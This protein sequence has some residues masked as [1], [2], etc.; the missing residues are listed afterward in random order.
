MAPLEQWNTPSQPAGAEAAKSDK[1]GVDRP[2]DGRMLT[3][4]QFHRLA[5]V[6]PE[7]EWFANIENHHTRRNYQNDVRDFVQFIGMEGQEEFRVVARAHLIAWRQDL[8]NR[9]LAPATIRRKLSALTSLFDYLC[10]QNAITHNPVKGV[11]RPKEGTNEGKTPAL[12]DDQAR[13]LLRQPATDTLQGKRD[14][15]IL[16]ALLY[17]GLRREEL[18]KLKVRDFHTREGLMHLKLERKGGKIRYEAVN[19]TTVTFITEYLRA[20]GHEEELNAPLFRPVKMKTSQQA[21]T[22][23]HTNTIMHLVK[24]YAKEAGVFFPG[25]SPHAM[26]AT[27]AT[28]ALNHGADIAKVQDWLGHANIATTRLYDKR[29][30]RPEESPTFKVEY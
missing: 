12:S 9:G 29:G 24:K 2:T 4:E 13:L 18:C 22:P 17:M 28:N 25:C 1:Q 15:A 3:N 7:A 6:P 30:R 11:Q 26:R 8:K 23:L 19:P 21:D 20:A 16:A 27:A 10:E 5:D 14:R